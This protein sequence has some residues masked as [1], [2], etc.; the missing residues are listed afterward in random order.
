MAR[1]PGRHAGKPGRRSFPAESTSIEPTPHNRWPEYDRTRATTVDAAPGRL[2][3]RLRR[4][5]GRR[6][7]PLAVRPIGGAGRGRR[8][9]DRSPAT[10][11]QPRLRDGRPARRRRRPRAAPGRPTHRAGRPR[12]EPVLRI[13]VHAHPI[14]PR[15]SVAEQRYET[16]RHCH[17][18]LLITPSWLR[19][20]A[21]L[22]RR[23]VLP[24][25]ADCACA[26][27]DA[28]RTAQPQDCRTTPIAGSS[29]AT[30][31]MGSGTLISKNETTG[32]VLTCSHLFDDRRVEHRRRVSR[33][34]PLRRAADRPRSGKRPGGP[35]D[36]AARRRARSR[37][38]TRS[39]SACS[40]RAAT[41][42][43][44]SFGQ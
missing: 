19:A 1:R 8:R 12:A 4:R 21:S 37:S 25:A 31:A 17:C 32:L 10:V 27:R 34:Q 40:R 42:A 39:P 24:A 26:T 9:R 33:R 18:C 5:A 41:A 7:A 44:A 38:T 14:K 11:L 15:P 22:L 36:S 20:S 3:L 35:V 23:R 2:R 6:D 43:T 13:P 28:G 30:A 29:S 16:L